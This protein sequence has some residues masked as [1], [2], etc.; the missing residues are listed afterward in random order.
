MSDEQKNLAVMVVNPKPKRAP[1]LYF[2]VGVKLLKGVTALL[3]ALGAFNLTD[4]NLPEDFRK[5][6]EFL[7]IDPEKKFFLELADRISEITPANLEWV[8]VGS[9]VYGLFMLLQAVGLALRVSWAV[10]LVIGESAFFIPIEVFEL[11][12]RRVPNESHPHLFGHPKISVAII[13][14]VNIAI[15]WYLFKNRERIIRHHRSH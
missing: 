6:L 4:N 11:I 14:A 15:V 12:R 13:L 7:H 9:V 3:L 1:T 5:V 8:A 10:W 2:I